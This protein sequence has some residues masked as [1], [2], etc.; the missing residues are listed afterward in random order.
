MPYLGDAIGTRPFPL[1][2]SE[3]AARVALHGISLEGAG[4]QHV[5]LASDVAVGAADEVEDDLPVVEACSLSSSTFRSRVM[6]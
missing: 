6:V 5:L 4:E 3:V 2:K 1:R